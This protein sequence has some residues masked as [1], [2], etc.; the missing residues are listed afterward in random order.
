MIKGI[1]ATFGILGLIALIIAILV[2][3]PLATIWSV[4]T[5]FSLGI[6]YTFK[7]WLAT[8]WIQMVTFGNVTTAINNNKKSA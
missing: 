5:L 4:N 3:A 8:V 7:T 1:L 6:E 2:F